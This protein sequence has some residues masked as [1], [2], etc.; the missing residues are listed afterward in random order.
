MLLLVADDEDGGRGVAGP[1]HSRCSSCR[2]EGTDPS[3]GPCVCVSVPGDI[4]I[5]VVLM[6]VALTSPAPDDEDDEDD[7]DDDGAVTV[8]VAVVAAVGGD[9]LASSP[10][11]RSAQ[12]LE[13]DFWLFP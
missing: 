12:G 2:H 7:D 6:G 5:I 3:A 4:V 8:C 1:T 10:R 13:L 11:S 9:S